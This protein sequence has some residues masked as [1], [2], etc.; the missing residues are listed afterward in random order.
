M[1]TD[2]RSNLSSKNKSLF[3]VLSTQTSGSLTA[4]ALELGAGSIL[5]VGEAVPSLSSHNCNENLDFTPKT[6]VK[7]SSSQKKTAH[8]SYT[9]VKSF[10]DHHG[11]ERVGVLT[12]TN[13]TKVY[14]PK[15]MKKK[16]A[17]FRTGV[18]DDLFDDW[19]LFMEPHKDFSVHLHVLVACKEDIR[20]GFRFEDLTDATIHPRARYKSAN[21][22]LRELWAILGNQKKPAKVAAYGFGRNELLPVKCDNPDAIGYYL[23]GYVSKGIC[24]RPPNFKKARLV[25]YKQNSPS[26]TATSN[27][28][29]NTEG[30]RQ[31]RLKIN[32][33]AKEA[34]YNNSDEIKADHGPR[35]AYHLSDYIFALPDVTEATDAPEK[36]QDAP[37]IVRGWWKGRRYVY[38]TNCKRRAVDFTPDDLWNPDYLKEDEFF[39]FLEDVEAE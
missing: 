18:L 9:N 16:W 30:S 29:W 14:E 33:F 1:L 39:N 25:T 15:Q 22:A 20:S 36:P 11:I 35:W 31:W 2:S 4:T 26:R 3:D 34:G 28:V 17:S 19:I 37:Q 27:F 21:P 7:L 10:I 24:S 12:L 32:K 38:F 8:A 6:Q 13:P 5:T 23:A